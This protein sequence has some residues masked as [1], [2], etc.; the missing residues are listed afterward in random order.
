MVKKG[1]SGAMPR[2]KPEPVQP[3]NEARAFAEP[4]AVDMRPLKAA[5]QE[6][7]PSHPA[8]AVII[9]E[10]DTLSSEEYAAKAVVWFRLLRL[11]ED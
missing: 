11:A 2:S 6:L 3:S 10:P 1:F 8:R 7:K 5:V 4:G 9:A